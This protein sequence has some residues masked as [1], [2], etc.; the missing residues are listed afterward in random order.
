[1][2]SKNGRVEQWLFLNDVEW[3]WM[4]DS[5]W[6]QMV[7]NSIKW[8]WMALNGIKWYQTVWNVLNGIKWYRMLSNVPPQ[9][10][11]QKISIHLSHTKTTSWFAKLQI[12]VSCVVA[13]TSTR[14][15]APPSPFSSLVRV[16][17]H[18]LSTRSILS[19]TTHSHHS[20][21]AAALL[22]RGYQPYWAHTKTLL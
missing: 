2:F 18:T 19:T 21:T 16:S 12:L 13:G 8:Y 7:S 9:P 4:N 17:V 22:P 20:N 1:M 6:F 5:K 10:F 3:F 15:N 14:Q 11:Q